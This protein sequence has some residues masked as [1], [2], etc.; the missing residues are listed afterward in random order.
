MTP[1]VIKIII[2]LWE[3][4]VEIYQASLMGEPDLKPVGTVN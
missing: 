4:V 2:S 3:V 1:D